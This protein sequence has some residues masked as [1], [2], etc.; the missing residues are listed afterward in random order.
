MN[1]GAV[2]NRVRAVQKRVNIIIFIKSFIRALWFVGIVATLILFLSKFTYIPYSAFYILGALVF[3]VAIHIA[4][5]LF[6]SLKETALFID[7][8]L[9]TKEVITE[10]VEIESGDISETEQA[11]SRDAVEKADHI[12][13]DK[14]SDV[15]TVFY[16]PADL[17][18]N[19]AI[20]ALCALITLI[21]S[22]TPPSDE[23]NDGEPQA[24]AEDETINNLTAL[25]KKLERQA[26]KLA[27]AELMKFAKEIAQLA[28]KLEKQEIT[29]KHAVARADKIKT[30]LNKLKQD[31]DAKRALLDKMSQETFMKELAKAMELSKHDDVSQLAEKLAEEKGSELKESI[32]KLQSEGQESKRM[33]DKPYKS[34]KS[35]DY[36]KFAKDMQSL[37]ENLENLPF[38]DSEFDEDMEDALSQLDELEDELLERQLAREKLSEEGDES[39]SDKVA[40]DSEVEEEDSGE[41]S[42]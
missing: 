19:C 14:S 7:R 5:P 32:K 38:D 16:K 24:K 23:R 26:H 41:E 2:C 39:D 20:L 25:S 18:M 9:K 8:Q 37:S 15:T 33:L 17:V 4:R 27:N 31:A 36:N 12:L 10:A 42:T 1:M 29:K 34:L 11:L 28:K 3:L 22:F 21:P 13:N 35:G 6:L 40:D 30:E